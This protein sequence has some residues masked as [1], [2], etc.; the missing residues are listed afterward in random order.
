VELNKFD[1]VLMDMQMPR[2]SGLEATAAIRQREQKTGGHVPII[3]LTANALAGHRENCL[4]AGMD[5]Y[6]TKPIRLHELLDAMRRVVP[7]L[8]LQKPNASAVTRQKQG[9]ETGFG[10]EADCE[11]GVFDRAA[12]L[13]SVGGNNTLLRELVRLSLDSDAPR[14]INELRAA[15]TKRD[16]RAL[17]AASHALKGLLGELRAG[18]ASEMAGQLEA[19]G[20]AGNLANLDARV[21]ALLLELEPLQRQ[22]RQFLETQ[23][24]S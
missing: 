22:W 23:N 4:R 14:L 21:A 2:R 11:R 16:P 18:R 24:N 8:L 6:V 20:H 15:A 17:E 5:D 10:T 1:L 9:K 13:E 7:D 3:A 12:L 19:D